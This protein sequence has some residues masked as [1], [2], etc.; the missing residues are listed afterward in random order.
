MLSDRKVRI[1]MVN[2]INTAPLYDIWQ[3]TVK[4]PEWNIVEAAPAVLNRMLHADELDMVW[5]FSWRFNMAATVKRRFPPSNGSLLPVL[6]MLFT[7]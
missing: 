4:R 1:G 6:L 5:C 3:R 2:F 7:V